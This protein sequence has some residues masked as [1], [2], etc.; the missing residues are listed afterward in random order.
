[1]QD[2][3]AR[4]LVSRRRVERIEPLDLGDRRA[5]QGG[6]G[7][8]ARAFGIG[9]VGDERELRVALG[10]GEVVKLEVVG[11][12]AAALGR[13][14]HRRDRDHRP[15]LGRDAAGQAETRQPHRPGRFADQAVDDRDHRLGGRED[16]QQ[17]RQR[18]QPRRRVAG[19]EDGAVA[20]KHPEDQGGGRRADRAQVGGKR[21][22]LQAPIP[23]ERAVVGEAEGTA[24]LAAAGA[25]QP[26]VG[27]GARVDV[28]ALRRRFSAVH[29][30][31]QRRRDLALA[32][33]ALARQQL[34]RVQRL[35]AR[36]VALG[37]ERRRGQHQP[38]QH[39]CRGDD[40]GPVGIADRSQRRDRVAD[41][42]VVGG[43]RRRQAGLDLG[44]V[45]RDPVE[46]LEEAH[47]G[48]RAVVLELLRHLRHERLADGAL[49]EE[50]EDGVELLRAVALDPV[51]AQVG[52]LARRLV[53]GG[54][55]GEPAQVLDQD[56]AQRRRQRPQ[57]A[58]RQ[59]ADVLVGAQEMDEQ[60]VVEG[61]VGVGDER[62]GDAVDSRQADQRLVFQH[63]QVAE[64]A[65]RQ[66]VLD[67]A[68]LRFDQMKV[69]EQPLG[70]GADL[71]ARRRVAGDVA[72]RLA[73][74]ADV[75][76][77]AREECA[78]ALARE[79]RGMRF[80]E[81]AAVLR[82]ALGPEDLGAVRPFERAAPG[83]EDLAQLGRR[84]GHQPQQVGR[85]HL[86]SCEAIYRDRVCL[87]NR[88]NQGAKRSRVV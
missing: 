46:P 10:V 43:L 33:P 35:V 50:R 1:M 66:A 18:R 31:E 69:V 49:V 81:A 56:D 51:A 14:Q 55:L 58:E 11:E 53:G 23:G 7:G 2:D 28:A 37:G 26:V 72:L 8:V 21:R 79:R 44:E 20:D 71:V 88:P 4:R 63:R 62:P 64:V 15:V 29:E 39:A 80:G 5:E 22:A 40:V 86:R 65:P 45:R 30:A 27:D 60:I 85:G 48:R 83:I 59:L 47:V 82:E 17:R 73:Q 74:D 78:R 38:R 19:R 84:I 68:R 41:A 75:L 24:Q 25:A 70:R 12:I 76:A 6:V 34:D 52:D 54:A 87:G 57:L 77:Q 3:E 42:Q 32:V 36:V 13:G 9:P 16:H 61:T 67:L